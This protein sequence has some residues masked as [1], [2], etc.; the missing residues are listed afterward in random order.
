MKEAMKKEITESM[1][2][3]VRSAFRAFMRSGVLDPIVENC[4]SL[5]GVVGK[6]INGTDDE[7]RRLIEERREKVVENRVTAEKE[8]LYDLMRMP[9]GEATTQQQKNQQHHKEKKME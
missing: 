3:D 5:P 4:C 9:F 8:R 2:S 1:K 7:M 6:N